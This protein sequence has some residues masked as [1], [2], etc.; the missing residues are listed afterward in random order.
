MVVAMTKEE[1]KWWQ[2]E[3]RV[4]K[5]AEFGEVGL[6]TSCAHHWKNHK[7]VSGCRIL[8]GGCHCEEKVCHFYKKKG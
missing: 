6:K 5:V 3:F 8:S 7:G 2:T 4:K 1:L